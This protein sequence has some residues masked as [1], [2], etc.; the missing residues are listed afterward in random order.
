M[1]ATMLRHGKDKL[2]CA[3]RRVSVDLSCDGPESNSLGSSRMTLAVRWKCARSRATATSERR[4]QRGLQELLVLPLHAA[5]GNGARSR[6][7]A[8]AMMLVGQLI[9]EVQQ[10]ARPAAADE[11]AVERQVQRLPFRVVLE[12]AVRQ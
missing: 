3:Q 12:L 8:V 10:P 5:L 11:R 7:A 4:F 1:A 9:A 2:A 6:E